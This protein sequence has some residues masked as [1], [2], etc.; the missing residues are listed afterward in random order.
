MSSFES[1]L[2]LN[3]RVSHPV[4]VHGLVVSE[5]HSSNSLSSDVTESRHSSEDGPLGESEL[6]VLEV[7]KH[8]GVH[9]ASSTGSSDSH[10]E[11]E[12]KGNHT[13]LSLEELGLAHEVS[14]GS[15]DDL[16]GSI[17]GGVRVLE[18]TV[19]VGVDD[20]EVVVVSWHFC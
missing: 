16:I 19:V 17:V 3:E 13:S 9:S 2:G 4:V 11:L 7:V 20:S 15:I 12:H 14:I 1:V 10:T 5:S 18:S 6:S 8:T